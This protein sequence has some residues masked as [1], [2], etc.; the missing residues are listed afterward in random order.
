[1]YYD[2]GKTLE[3][4]D[5]RNPLSSS[6]YSELLDNSF[7][8]N[9][10][11]NQTTKT[12]WHLQCTSL[13]RSEAIGRESQWDSNGGSLPERAFLVRGAAIRAVYADLAL[14]CKTCDARNAISCFLHAIAHEM[15]VR[16]S[17]IS[18]SY[19]YPAKPQGCQYIEALGFSSRNPDRDSWSVNCNHEGK[20]SEIGSSPG[21][22]VIGFRSE[23]V[24]QFARPLDS[25]ASRGQI[26]Q[27]ETITRDDESTPRSAPRERR[28][29][30]QR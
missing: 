30:T 13:G 16:G 24:I 9:R 8:F 22:G 20:R 11:K 15:P 14:F 17:D 18:D 3:Q 4:L 27:V 26:Q 7:I 21:S 5:R 12:V 25:M 10:L 6:S 1:M 23:P 2:R 29:Q 19:R 28:T